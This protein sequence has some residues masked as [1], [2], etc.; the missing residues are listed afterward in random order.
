[1]TTFI[2]MAEYLIPYM[3]AEM[4]I[5]YE[6]KEEIKNDKYYALKLKI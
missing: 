6:R 2:I 3:L 5:L 4:I 1:M